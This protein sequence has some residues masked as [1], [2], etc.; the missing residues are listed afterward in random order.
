MEHER[1][2]SFAGMEPVRLRDELFVVRAVLGEL[3]Q[4]RAQFAVLLEVAFLGLLVKLQH[5]VRSAER[6]QQAS[7]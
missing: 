4:L 1:A 7:S 5:G 6:M 2:H 3:R